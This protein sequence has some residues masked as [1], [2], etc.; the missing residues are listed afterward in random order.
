MCGIG[1]IFYFSQK[2]VQERQLHEINK[3]MRHRGPDDD[4]I[5]IDENLGLAHRR[6]KIIDLSQKASQP[7]ISHNKRFVIS[8]NGECY[9]YKELRED[10]KKN[11]IFVQGKSDTEVVLECFSY[12]GVT[13]FSRINGMFAIAIW[14]IKKKELILAR[15]RFG[16]KPLYFH[17]DNE[18]FVFASEIKPLLASGIDFSLDH[19][20]LYDFFTL[21]YVPSNETLFKGIKSFKPAHY[22]I[23]GREKIASRCYW[24]LPSTKQSFSPEHLCDLLSSS[25][26]YRLRSDVSLGIFLSGGLDSASIAEMTR[27][28]GSKVDTFTFDVQGRDSEVKQARE[29]ASFCKHNA[30]HVDRVDLESLEKIISSLEEPIGDSII[31]PSYSLSQKAKNHVKVILSGEGADEVF[32]GYVHHMVLYWLNKFK[33]MRKVMAVL[34]R[35]IPSGIL[36]VCLPYCQNLDRSSLD[37]VVNDLHRF[38]GSMVESRNF[39]RMFSRNELNTYLNRDLNMPSFSMKNESGFLNSLTRMDLRDWNNRYTLHRFDR[40]TMAHSLEGRVPF[41][42]HRLVEYVISLRDTDRI[43]LFCQKKSLR[44]AMMKSGLSKSLCMKKKQSFVFP[45]IKRQHFYFQQKLEQVFLDKRENLQNGIWNEK[46]LL[47]LIEKSNRRTFIEDK[48]IFCF[49]VFELWRQ[50]FETKRWESMR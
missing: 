45:F 1:G 9:N 2:K 33:K 40:L 35:S 18:R 22:M 20:K 17:H 37:K 43:N 38:D 49:L 16:I 3:Y 4:G 21:R 12:W 5:F 36:N 8:Y 13:A 48:K 31:L 15:D 50:I 19:E 29:I 26:K 47:K 27:V 44:K 32:N 23:I 28:N 30:H 46:S 6:L 24:K 41:L 14:D 39:I 42:D 34:G 7:M 10:L 11:G 25:V